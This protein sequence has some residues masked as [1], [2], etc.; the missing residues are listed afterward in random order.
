MRCRAHAAT[1]CRCRRP[2]LLPEPHC[3]APPRLPM[4]AARRPR[5]ACARVDNHNGNTRVAGRVP[6]SPHHLMRCA[7]TAAVVMAT[8]ALAQ[9]PAP[10]PANPW[11]AAAPFPEPS[12]EVLSATANNKLYVFAGLAPG[13]KPKSLVFEYDPASNQ[14]GKQKPMKLPSHHV[15]FASLNNKIYAFG[16]FM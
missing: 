9:A 12:E 1:L 15:A 10:S 8:P 2:G 14:W 13:W 11:F 6:M 7:L 5:P 4:L 16:G 3:A